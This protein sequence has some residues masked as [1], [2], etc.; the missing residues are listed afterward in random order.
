MS[1]A[2]C[3]SP[4]ASLPEEAP[5]NE[6]YTRF[7]NHPV[8][9]ATDGDFCQASQPTQHHA[10]P[11]LANTRSAWLV[12]LQDLSQLSHASFEEPALATQKDN[13]AEIP[14]WKHFAVELPDGE[15]W[16]Q[17]PGERVP[18]PPPCAN[19]SDQPRSPATPKTKLAAICLDPG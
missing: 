7:P 16:T 15:Q 10:K 11:M 1:S 4:S 8:R 12:A 6:I 14:P 13:V 17:A 19:A 18:R 3:F 5:R 2:F 9:A